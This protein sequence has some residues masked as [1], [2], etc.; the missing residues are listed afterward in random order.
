MNL[1]NRITLTRILLSLVL[2]FIL[3]FPFD[4]AGFVTPKLFINESIVVDIKYIVAGILFMV[5][6]LSDFIDGYL[7]RKY[8][9]V[10]DLGKMMDAIADKI[11]V[12]S[13][14]IILASVGFISVVIPVVIVTRDIVVDSIKMVIGSKGQVVGA[15]YTGKVK[16]ACLMVGIV[17]TLFYNLP[18]E[19]LNFKVADALL[20]IACVLAI[21]SAYQY[22]MMG[23]PYLFPK[24]ERTSRKK[25]KTG[26]VE[27]KQVTDSSLHDEMIERLRRKEQ[28][29]KIEL[30][31][32]FSI[33]ESLF[34]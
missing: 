8:N 19:L 12:D 27:V 3:L 23:K 16:S 31:W 22:F 4:A 2:I 7:A 34:W 30:W 15:I 25:E 32:R 26:A 33:F 11:L 17:L 20:I 21:I 24:N 1:P 29:E 10:T 13:V 9:L 18:F 28:E 6:S 14:L 5:A